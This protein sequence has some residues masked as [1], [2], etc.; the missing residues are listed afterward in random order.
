MLITKKK[1][2]NLLAYRNDFV[3]SIFIPTTRTSNFQKDQLYLKNALQTAKQ[4]LEDRGMTTKETHQF[5]GKAYALLDDDNYWNHLSDG[6]ALF[7]GP[8]FFEKFEL[9]IAF[10]KQT[11]I[12][13][14]FYLRP[15]MPMMTGESRFFLLALSL[16]EV[17]FYEG[18]RYSITPVIIEDLVPED[19]ESVLVDI[20]AKE[21]LQMHQG[22]GN[23]AVFHGQNKATDKKLKNYEKYFRF[24]DK[25][26]MEMLHDE[27]VPMVIAAVDYLVPIYKD[28]SAYSNIVTEHINGNPERSTPVDLHRRAMN[29]LEDF[30][31]NQKA[32]L[33]NN[34]GDYLASDKASFSITDIVKSAHDGKVENLLINQDYQ[35]WGHYNEEKRLVVIH[36]EKQADSEDLIDLAAR[37]TYEQGGNVYTCT[38]EDL[39]RPTANINATYRF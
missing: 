3:V 16:N 29:I 32:K 12:G 35:S 36:K 17:K 24:I 6:L 28:V 8:D 20:G 4:G 1:F 15:V 10:N 14:K 33:K 23:Q 9:P 37:Y 18:S 5:L 19:M 13:G 39:P 7:I 31:Q 34:F 30:N 27:K 25:G 38:R 11:L 2:N 22:G 21:S 26:L